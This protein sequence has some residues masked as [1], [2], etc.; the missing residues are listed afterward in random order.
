MKNHIY[1]KDCK[2]KAILKIADTVTESVYLLTG[3]K[4]G[5]KW[6]FT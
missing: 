6:N 2:G 4:L 5:L 3:N 1:H